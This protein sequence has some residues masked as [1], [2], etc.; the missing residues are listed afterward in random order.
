MKGQMFG[1]FLFEVDYDQCLFTW[2]VVQPLDSDETKEVNEK[3][4]S[5]IL[6]LNNRETKILVDNR[7][8]LDEKGY[9]IVFPNSVN[10][11][12]IQ[13]QQW[14]KLYCKQIAVL[15]GTLLMKA[16]MDRL[17]KSS[18]LVDILRTFYHKDHK[19]SLDKAYEYLEISKSSLL[20]SG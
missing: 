19:K 11:E 2:K 3:I 8:L 16:Q 20:E 5:S 4:K 13:L 15:C 9:H 18:G 17:A 12:W 7:E 14:Q 1:K 10:Q 6:S